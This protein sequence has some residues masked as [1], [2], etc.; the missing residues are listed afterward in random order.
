MFIIDPILG[1]KEGS[2][3]EGRGKG[4][5]EA[6]YDI[7]DESETYTFEEVLKY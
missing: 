2:F 3:G 6:V 5:S 1:V 7:S 4:N